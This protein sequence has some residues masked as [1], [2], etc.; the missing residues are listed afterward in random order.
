MRRKILKV[1]IPNK[2]KEERRKKKEENI[3]DIDSSN[4]AV[5][6]SIKKRRYHIGAAKIE[7]RYNTNKLKEVKTT[8]ST[9]SIA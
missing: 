7:F 6:I 9:A 4:A 3:R 5:E 1:K 2:K 8:W